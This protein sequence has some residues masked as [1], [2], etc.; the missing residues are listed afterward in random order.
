MRTTKAHISLR[1]RAVWS[2]PL[3]FAA[4]IVR[5]KSLRTYRTTV[6]LLQAVFHANFSI[7]WG[8]MST[9]KKNLIDTKIVATCISTSGCL[10]HEF[11]C[12]MTSCIDGIKRCDRHKDCDN[13][14]DEEDC[15]EWCVGNP[16]LSNSRSHP[17]Q[18]DKSILDLRG[19]WCHV[20][21]CK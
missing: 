6:Y 16:Y 12:N 17:Y 11:Q 9:S 14:A 15:G 10:P 1:I 13:G 20:S 8:H 21:V 19:V 2:M 18:L 3:L 4:W 7:T 5:T